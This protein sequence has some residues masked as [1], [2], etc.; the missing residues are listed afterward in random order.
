MADGDIKKVITDGSDSNSKM[1]PFKEK[2]S[3]QEIDSLVKYIRTL[4]GK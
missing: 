3:E 1:K 2:L 4:K